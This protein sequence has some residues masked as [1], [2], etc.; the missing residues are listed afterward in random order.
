VA[1]LDIADLKMYGIVCKKRIIFFY[2]NFLVKFGKILPENLQ[3]CY[4]ICKVIYETI[5]SNSG[6]KRNKKSSKHFFQ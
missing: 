4:I 1:I 5:L 6:K 3:K 2:K